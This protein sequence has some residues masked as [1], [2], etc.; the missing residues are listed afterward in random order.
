MKML[1]KLMRWID[2]TNGSI[3]DLEEFEHVKE[4]LLGE[5]VTFF[6][7]T[8]P[9]NDFVYK[10]WD[11]YIERWHTYLIAFRRQAVVT[12][13]FRAAYKHE[14]RMETINFLKELLRDDDEIVRKN[15]QEAI[16][17]IEDSIKYNR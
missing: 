16:K 13:Q 8:T 12:L 7:I 2:H 10:Q 15:A 6:G 11:G 17:Y 14:D 5:F 3:H 1:P 9:T 4:P